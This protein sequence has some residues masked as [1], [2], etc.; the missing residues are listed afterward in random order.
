MTFGC[1][2]KGVAGRASVGMIGVDI[3]PIEGLIGEACQH[4]VRLAGMLSDAGIGCHRRIEQGKI[5]V[6]EMQFCRVAV[7]QDVSGE[8][9]LV[10]A[11]LGD[12]P[13]G[14]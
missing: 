3:D 10:G 8:I 7:R 6:D 1:G 2:G 13:A 4:F 12:A 5:E 9:A 14:R 11:D